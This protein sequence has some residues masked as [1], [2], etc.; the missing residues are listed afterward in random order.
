VFDPA[1]LG[2]ESDDVRNAAAAKW[3]AWRID[4]PLDS[5]DAR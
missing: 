4:H 5:D 3:R 2:M 1:S